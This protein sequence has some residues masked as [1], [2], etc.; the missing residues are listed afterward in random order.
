MHLLY[1][2]VRKS[3]FSEAQGFTKPAPGRRPT[4]CTFRCDCYPRG[5]SDV[6]KVNVRH[7]L[8]HRRPDSS[9]GVGYGALHDKLQHSVLSSTAS[10]CN[11]RCLQR[12]TSEV[13]N[14][15]CILYNAFLTELSPRVLI[16][17]GISN[18][19]RT[20]QQMVYRVSCVHNNIYYI[21]HLSLHISY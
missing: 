13:H 6:R 3:S 9:D 2:L 18:G 15:C 17:S 4:H 10:K 19:N 7:H 20:R 21:P 16:I 12:T 8:R 14:V 1:V 5:V 11:T